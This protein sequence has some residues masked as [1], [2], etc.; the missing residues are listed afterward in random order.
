MM[1]VVPR[2]HALLL[3]S[4]PRLRSCSNA[5]TVLDV[6]HVPYR[7]CTVAVEGRPPL[8]RAWHSATVLPLSLGALPR[9]AAG[10]QMLL[11]RHSTRELLPTDAVEAAR[12]AT[13]RVLR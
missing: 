2:A 5:L 10:A 11:A 13:A 7:V 12:T 4:T 6:N 3:S 1:A 8:P 9:A